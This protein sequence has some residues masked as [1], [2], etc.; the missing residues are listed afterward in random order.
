MATPSRL[1]KL[2]LQGR[3]GTEK[4]TLDSYIQTVEF[5]VVAVASAGVQSTNVPT[6][7]KSMQVIS[8]YLQVETAEATAVTK[9]VDIGVTGVTEAIQADTSVAATGARGTYA[10]VAVN[11]NASSVFTYTLAGAD[12][13]ELEAVCVVTFQGIDA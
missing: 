2:G 4:N 8:S 13:A 11:T 9:T 1:S 5:P 3:K 12:F 6:P 10:T 7:T